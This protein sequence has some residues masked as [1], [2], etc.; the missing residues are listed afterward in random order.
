MTYCR[1]GSPE[2]I[3][4][5]LTFAWH[6][7]IRLF[8]RITRATTRSDDVGLAVFKK[9]ST[10]D[11]KYPPN[12]AIK[13]FYP[14]LNISPHRTPATYKTLHSFR[15][16]SSRRS[17]SFRSTWHAGES[18]VEL[19]PHRLCITLTEN[20][21]FRLDGTFNAYTKFRFRNAVEPIRCVVMYPWDIAS[22]ECASRWYDGECELTSSG[23]FEGI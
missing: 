18:S 23:A 8:T 13:A 21:C 14:S 19:V 4:S 16:S 1:S 7:L 15:K 10:L 9:D 22:P 6:G 3:R 2:G 11:P 5:S 12:F 17:R 20:R